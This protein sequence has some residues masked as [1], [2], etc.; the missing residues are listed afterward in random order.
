[1]HSAGAAQPRG[2]AVAQ[3]PAQGWPRPLC[4]SLGLLLGEAA[5][6]PEK[7]LRRAKHFTF[8]SLTSC[9][10][11]GQPAQASEALESLAP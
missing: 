4:A 10:K 5:S 1:M 8:P 2:Q 6:F 3:A 9:L 11:P 7:L